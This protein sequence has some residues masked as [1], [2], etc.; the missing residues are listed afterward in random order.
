VTPLAT[1]GRI[2]IRRFLPTDLGAFYAAIDESRAT[3]ATWL[4]WMHPAYTIADT[5]DWL[6]KRDAEWDAGTDFPML[7]ADAA[8]GEVLGSAGLN[9]VNREHRFANLGY[10]TRA[11]RL[12]LGI[13][14]AAARLVAR[15]AFV[16]A[17]FGR[18]EIV[19]ALGNVASR[20]AAERSGA[21]F[22]GVA[23]NRLML[24]DDWHDAAV[25]AFVPGDVA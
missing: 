8:T 18:I 13:A 10:W 9:Q 3:L 23:R 15:W 5:A 17:G 16:E 24:R 25:Y 2:A 14:P 7:V 12:G 20:R 1:D 22:E 21:R 4:P 19:V 6:G 11:S